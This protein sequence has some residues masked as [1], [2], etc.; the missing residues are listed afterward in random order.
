MGELIRA[1]PE[2]EEGAHLEGPELLGLCM[3]IQPPQKHEAQLLLRDR[4]VC[5]TVWL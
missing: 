1:R 2:S 4:G 3:E 5:S